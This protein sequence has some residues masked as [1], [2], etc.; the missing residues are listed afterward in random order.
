MLG[1]LNAREI[2][3]QEKRVRRRFHR[4]DL[5]GAIK[6]CISLKTIQRRKY[7]VKGSNSLW[8]VDGNHK[9]IR[10]VAFYHFVFHTEKQSERKQSQ[11]R[12]VL[13]ECVRI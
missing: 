9:L 4:I 8:H 7:N 10:L 1:H 5:E 6:R 12:I 11:F 13:N 3:V 2:R